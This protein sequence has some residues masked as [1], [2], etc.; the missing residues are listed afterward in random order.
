M[1]Q[2]IYT[3]CN[4]ENGAHIECTEDFLNEWLERGFEIESTRQGRLLTEEA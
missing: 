3:M 1:E 4:K 2:T